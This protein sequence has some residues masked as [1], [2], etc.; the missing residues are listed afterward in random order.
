MTFSGLWAKNF[1]KVVK[2]ALYV[3]IAGFWG[4]IYF[5]WTFSDFDEIFVGR[6]VKVALHE[7]GGTFEEFFEYKIIF[8]NFEE[9]F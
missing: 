2:I 6:V 9:I 1:W 3:S 4:K 8:S 7:L 5:E